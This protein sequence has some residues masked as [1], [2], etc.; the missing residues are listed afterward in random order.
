M[1]GTCTILQSEFVRLYTDYKK[2]YEYNKTKHQ[3]HL[4]S[5]PH[6]DLLWGVFVSGGIFP[7]KRNDYQRFEKDSDM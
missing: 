2:K 1:Y 3:R 5:S 7:E 6:S 4:Y